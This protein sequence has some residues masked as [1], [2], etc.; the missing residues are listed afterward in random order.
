MLCLAALLVAVAYIAP[1]DGWKIGPWYTIKYPTVDRLLGVA[2]PEYADISATIAMADSMLEAAREDT[3]E[4]ALLTIDTLVA[5][6]ADT[7]VKIHR[8]MVNIDSLRAAQ[9]N[10][11]PLEFADN[12]PSVLYTFFRALDQASLSKSKTHVFHYG[13]S[14][15]EGDRMTSYI[16]DRLQKRFGG[17]G[18]GMLPLSNEN[19]IRIIGHECSENWHRYPG[20]FKEGERGGTNAYGAM[21]VY[22][23][24]T[25]MP[26]DSLLS[27]KQVDSAWV[28]YDAKRA[29]FNKCKEFQQLRLF[30]GPVHDAVKLTFPIGDTT[31]TDYLK[32]QKLVNT[33]RLDFSEKNSEML[34]QFASKISPQFY[35]VSLEGNSGVNVTNI[36]MRGSA[37][38][39]FHKIDLDVFGAM[40]R[41]M[42][43]SL[44]ILQ[45]GG[46][47]MPY[48]KDSLQV[49]SYGRMFKSQIKH[50]QKAYDRASIIVIGPADMS[51][52]DGEFYKTYPLLP[53]VRD[54]LK[55]AAFESG[56]AYW[57]MYE[58]MGGHNAMPSWVEAEPPLAGAD[59]THFT[60]RGARIIS[61]FFYKALILEYE[62]YKNIFAHAQ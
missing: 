46:N 23:S 28:R 52:K 16:R 11:R 33:V 21:M 45:Y 31:F 4:V 17:S 47:V 48:I 58:A 20:F 15:I 14:Q 37:G 24:Y 29:I 9:S 43:T 25:P 8:K 50:I 3:V 38:T 41:E 54:A 56:A 60:P 40:H 55:T 13:D 59:Y 10:I 6:S 1:T 2:D 49:A 18:P 34:L 26:T 27:N 51:L 30:H 57:D 5:D 12:N 61:E 22:A 62:A 35:G 32:G 53:A 42:K 39:V 36:A 7:I 44:I 19:Q